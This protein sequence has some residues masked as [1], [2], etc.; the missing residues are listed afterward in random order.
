[1]GMGRKRSTRKMKRKTNQKKKKNKLKRI[2]AAK[3]NN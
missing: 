1:M 2:L 3:K